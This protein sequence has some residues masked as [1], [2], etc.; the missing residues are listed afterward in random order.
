MKS[1]LGAKEGKEQAPSVKYLEDAGLVGGARAPVDS[2]AAW[3][4]PANQVAALRSAS[5]RSSISSL[6]CGRFLS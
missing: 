1:L 4:D 2:P 3:L 6:P 5:P